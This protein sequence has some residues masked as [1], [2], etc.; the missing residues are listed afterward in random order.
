MYDYNLESRRNLSTHSKIVG[1]ALDGYSIY[2]YTGWNDDGEV[3]EM[4][5][6]YRLKEG[7]MVLEELMTMNMFKDS[8]H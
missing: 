3:V 2:G 8:E 4:T 5:S 1:F 6:S 7:A